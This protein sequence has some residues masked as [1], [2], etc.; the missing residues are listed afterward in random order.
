MLLIH[1]F[2]FSTNLSKCESKRFMTSDLFQYIRISRC[3]PVCFHNI[4]I[5][6]QDILVDLKDSQIKFKTRITPTPLLL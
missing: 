2:I 5:I 4:I 6:I 3:D 1:A